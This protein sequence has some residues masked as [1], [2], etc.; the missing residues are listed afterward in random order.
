MQKKSNVTVEVIRKTF[1][2]RN[3]TVTKLSAEFYYI[4]KLYFDMFTDE[5]FS[6]IKINLITK[7]EIHLNSRNSFSFLCKLTI[8]RNTYR[9]TKNKSKNGLN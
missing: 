8:K 2:C 3:E 6:N 7:F 1:R 9:G 4:S 5:Y